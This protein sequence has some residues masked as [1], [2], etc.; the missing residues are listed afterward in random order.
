MKMFTI[1]ASVAVLGWA[2]AAQAQQTG[3]IGF[4]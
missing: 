2:S 1:A 4:L 3:L